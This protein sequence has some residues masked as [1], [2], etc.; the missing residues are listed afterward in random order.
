MTSVKLGIFD[1]QKQLVVLV[2]EMF[3]WWS[4]VMYYC[5]IEIFSNSLRINL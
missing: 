4:Q 5:I 1:M 3:L 2:F